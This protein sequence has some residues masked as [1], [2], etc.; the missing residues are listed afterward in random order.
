MTIP[1][2]S[3]VISPARTPKGSDGPDMDMNWSCGHGPHMASLDAPQHELPFRTPTRLV[4]T[5]GKPEL[6]TIKLSA[7]VA[8]ACRQAGFTH[9][10]IRMD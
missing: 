4:M 10:L 6:R 8:T 2:K 7:L 1:K 5:D 3:R 9:A